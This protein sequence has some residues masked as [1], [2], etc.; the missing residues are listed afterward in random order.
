[1][2][3]GSGSSLYDGVVEFAVGS[4]G[5]LQSLG[6]LYTKDGL[7]IF[8][9]LFVYV[10]WRARSAGSAEQMASAL[11]APLV[12]LA[13]Y[14]VSE[15]SKTFIHEERPCRG[16]PETATVLKCPDVGDWSFP[17]NHSAIAAS[18]A[19]GLLFAWR[20]LTPWVVTMALA[21]AF[22]RVFVGAH[23]PHDVLAGLVVGAG[24]AWPLVRLTTARA[25]ELV[26]KF[27]E[28]PRLAFALGIVATPELEPEL[29]PVPRPANEEPTQVLPRQRPQRPRGSD[30]PTVRLPAQS[31]PRQAVQ[32]V[33][34]RQPPRPPRP[35]HPDDR[36]S[37][38]RP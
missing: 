11:L 23:Y 6:S 7:L 20:K 36:V 9:V 5:W 1:M 18:A 37:R 38:P 19:V 21:M 22:S 34:R 33:E 29:E 25:T 27:G 28:N 12:T 26:V 2:T 35:P 4:P 13:A 24:V 30:Q 8:G 16:L 31:R 32:A 10:W 3:T 14:L 17:S 15:V